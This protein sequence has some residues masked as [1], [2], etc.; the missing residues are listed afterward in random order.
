[1]AGW[2]YQF[3]AKLNFVRESWTAPVDALRVHPAEDA[4]VVATEQVK[5]LLSRLGRGEAD[6]LFVFDAGY[7]LLK[8]QQG[9]EGWPCQIL[10]RLRAGRCFRADPYLAGP[11][12]HTAGLDATGRR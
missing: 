5:A 4:N 12:A 3:I 2:A 11:P 7:D 8:V 10:V 6:P 1:M 9:L